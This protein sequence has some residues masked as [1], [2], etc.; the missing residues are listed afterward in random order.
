MKKQIFSFILFLL[1]IATLVGGVFYVVQ[2]NTHADLANTNLC[3]PENPNPEVS[4][5]SE[6]EQ[7]ICVL[8]A[9][10]N[11]LISKESAKLGATIFI[12]AS[13]TFASLGCLG[14]KKK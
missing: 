10:Q 8:T 6:A 12:F 2:Y 4:A 1:S 9:S 13:I 3:Y 7:T 11:D 5:F 14:K